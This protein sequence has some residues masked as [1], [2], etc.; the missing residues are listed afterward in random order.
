MKMFQMDL[1]KLREENEKLKSMLEQVT[2]NYN[3]LHAQLQVAM[4]RQLHQIHRE[5][6]V[7]FK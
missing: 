5:E 4:Q 3:G 7:T 6:Q 1:E 2:R